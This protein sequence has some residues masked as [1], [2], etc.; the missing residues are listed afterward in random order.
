M[1]AKKI[2][3]P[4][5]LLPMPNKDTAKQTSGQWIYKDNHVTNGI[6]IIASV[7]GFNTEEKR[8]NGKLIASAPSLSSQLL[9]ANE[10]IARLRKALEALYKM[11]LQAEQ[12]K[13]TSFADSIH[14]LHAEALQAAKEALK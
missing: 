13:T 9:S 5:K 8:A 2:I 10:E 6:E 12:Y 4:L 1:W 3:A 14:P 11:A 7:Y